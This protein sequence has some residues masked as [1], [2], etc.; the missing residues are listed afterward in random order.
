MSDVEPDIQ[1]YNETSH[2]LPLEHSQLNDTATSI[3]RREH[4]SFSFIELVYVDENEI[5]RLNR[6]HLGRD[7]ITDIITF[8]YDD[9]EDNNA[10]EGTLYC[11]APRIFEQARQFDEPPEKEFLRIFIHGLLHLSGYED[12]TDAQKQQ[13]TKKEDIFLEMANI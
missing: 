13:M 8:R 4:C 11:C 1:M 9:S 7:Y 2:N 3:S 12:Q 6:E 5:V 10:I